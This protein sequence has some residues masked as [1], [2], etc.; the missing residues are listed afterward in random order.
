[1]SRCGLIL[2]YL[3]N[4]Y[5][6][7]I[8][9][10]PNILCMLGSVVKDKKIISNLVRLFNELIFCSSTKIYLVSTCYSNSMAINAYFTDAV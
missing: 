7:R 4:T 2:Y 9:Q 10:H 5:L 8:V 3:M 1:M 6:C